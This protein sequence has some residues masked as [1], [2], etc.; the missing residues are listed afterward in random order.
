MKSRPLLILE[1]LEPRTVM[2]ADWNVVLIDSTLP[3]VQALAR[4]FAGE[5]HVMLYDGNHENA[6]QVLQRVTQAASS[7]GR[8]IGSLSILSHGT[9]GAFALGNELVSV[10]TIGRTAAAWR[11]IGRSMAPDGQIYLYGCSTAAGQVGSSLL[12]RLS[13]LTRA[14]V[15]GSTDVTGDGGDWILE[16]QSSSGFR[17]FSRVAIE[18]DVELLADF[19]GQLAW[20]GATSGTSNDA[21]HDYNNTANWSGGVID[22]SFAGVTLSGNTTLYFSASRT[23]GAGGMNLGYSG[24]FDLT[25]KSSSTTTRT[26]TLAGNLSGDLGAGNS[27]TVTLG[28]AAN[29][30]N[31]AVGA[32]R[33]LT[34]TGS[35][36]TLRLEN[37]ISGS[38]GI[39]VAGAGRVLIN[40][41]NTYSGATVIDAGATLQVG[42]GTNA[43]AQ[44]GNATSTTAASAVTVNGSLQ[45]S[46]SGSPATATYND[47][48]GIGNIVLLDSGSD[49]SLKWQ[50]DGGSFQGDAIVNA[51][52]RLQ[53]DAYGA[54]FADSS[55]ITVRSGGGLFVV[56]ANPWA[57]A[58]NLAGSGWTGD[59]FPYGALRLGPDDKTFSGTITLADDAQIF[60]T[61]AGDVFTFTGNI[62][63]GGAGHTLTVGG[64]SNTFILSGSN[65][66]GGGTIIAGTVQLGSSTALPVNGNVTLGSAARLGNLTTNASGILRL[67]GHSAE[68]GALTTDGTG[69]SNAVSNGSV[70]A[71]TLTIGG[72]D[73]TSTFSGTLSNGGS[74]ALSVAKIGSGTITLSAANAHSGTTTISGGILQL[75]NANAAQNS[76]VSIGLDNGLAFDGGIGSFAIGGLSGS[77][78]LALADTASA[79]VALSA[80]GA[81]GDTIHSGI[82]SGAGSLTKTG[83]GTLTLAGANAYAGGTTI[84][85][86]TLL[87]NNASGSA[88]GTG[89][90][91]V[92]S[93][94]T[95]GG[96]GS[97]SGAVTV[98]SGAAISPG[99]GGTSILITGNLT[100][101]S[102]ATLNATINTSTAGS[103]HDQLSIIGA[104]NLAGSTLSLSGSRTASPGEQIILISND[105]AD[106]VVGTFAGLAEGAPVTWNGAT[107][108]VS[109][110]GGSGNDVALTD[111]QFVSVSVDTTSD[112]ADGTTTSIAALLGD[113]GADGKISL[114]EAILAANNS[115]NAAGGADRI[116][117]N[118]AGAGVQTIAPASALPSITDAVVIDATSQ[119]GFGGSPII[120]I[121][122]SSAGAGINGLA[123]AVGSDGSTIR[124]LVINRFGGDGM[125]VSSNNN[126]IAGNFV[127]TDSSG[128]IDLGNSDDGIQVDGTGNLIG[129]SSAADRNV[130]SGN[131]YGI[132]LFGGSNT[133]RGNYIGVSAA[134]TADLGNAVN[135]IYTSGAG[136]TIGGAGAGEG[137]VISGNDNDGIFLGADSATIQGNFIG[138]D[139][140]GSAA[141]ANIGEGIKVEG[142]NNV[143]GGTTS[144]AGNVIANNAN[145]GI[146]LHFATAFGN[147]IQGNSIHTNG[148]LGIN[149]DITT[150]TPQPNDADDV[151]FGGPN[152]GQNYPI[153]TSA[154]FQGSDITV[155]GSLNST[156]GR[157]FRIEL[158]AG[159]AGDASGHGEGENYLGSFNITTDAGGD[160]SFSQALVA[161]VSLGAAISATATD[162]TTND[163]SEF[164]ATVS[165]TS[166]PTVTTTGSA[167]TYTEDDGAVAADGGLVITDPDSANL[168]GA[169]IQITGNYQNGQDLLSFTDTP[170]ITAT[171]DALTGTLT[172]SGSD[173]LANYQAA[174]RAVRYAN[175]SQ[176]PSTLTRS[177]SF[178]VRDETSTSPVA[179]RDITVAAV[180]DAPVITSDGGGAAASSNVAENTTAVTTV[181]ATDADGDTPTFSVTGGADAASFSINA[182]T[183]AIS[184]ISAPDYE[185]PT[186]SDVD[187]VYLV[188]VTADDGSTGT[189]SQ[190]ISVSVTNANESPTVATA[191]SATPSPVTGTTTNLSVLGGDDG[192]ESG[193]TYTWAAT[194][195][196]GGSSPAFSANGT[197]AA[198]NSTVTFDRIG[199]YTFTVTISDGSSSTTSSASVTVN[200][201]FTSV[202]VSPAAATLFPNQIQAFTATGKDQFGIA[203][204]TQPS[205]TWSLASG[206]GSIDSSSGLYTAPSSSGSATIS[207]QSGSVSGSGSVTIQPVG[208]FN[209][210]QDVGSPA[211]KGMSTFA[212][213]TYTIEGAGA[214]IWST[215]DQFQFAYLDFT[216]VGEITAR[217]TAVENTHSFAKGGVMFRDSTSANAAYA[218]VAYQPTG[219]VTFEY[220]ASNGATASFVGNAGASTPVWVR[221]VRGGADNDSFSGYYSTNGAT[222]N[223][224]G[225]QTITMGATAAV[226]LA[227]TSRDTAALNTSTFENVAVTNSTPS[228][229]TP[230]AATPSPVDGLTT[231]LSV[232]GADDGGES[233]L[234][235]TWSATTKP[236]GSNP[237]FSANVTNAAKNSTVTFDMAGDYTFEATISD[238]TSSITS[239]VTVTVNQT[240]TSITVS[241]SSVTVPTGQTQAFTATGY[242]QFGSAMSAQ[243]SMIW[244][245][246]SGVGSVDAS[247][248]YSAPGS[249]GSAVVK[250][251]SSSISGTASVNVSNTA[252]SIVTPAAAAPSPVT[253]TTTGLSVLGDDAGGEADLTYTWSVTSLPGGASAPTYSMNGT[254]SAK[255]TTATFTHAGTYVFQVAVS[256]GTDTTTDTVTVTVTQTL[257]SITV[258]PASASLN[259][260][261]TQQFTA[262]GYDQFGQE[263]AAQPAFTW[264]I[265]SG[266]GSVDAAGL[267]D[268]GASAGSAVVRAAS[269]AV[270]DDAAVTVFDAAPTIAT[271]AAASPSPAT[272]TT[273]ALGVLGAD[274]GGEANLT[275]TWSVTAKPV[276]ASDPT[277]SANGTNAAKDATATFSRA[278]DYTFEV[279]VADASGQ[280]VTSSVTV[281]VEQILSSITLSPGSASLNL[282]GAQQFSAT[283]HDQFG[284][285]MASQPS[286]T[287]SIASGVG[288][289]DSTGLYSAGASE[290]SATV[291]ATSAS[292]N[293]TASVTVTNAAPTVANPIADQNATEDVAYTFQF[294]ANVF[295]DVDG[296][297]SYTA[298]LDNGSPLPGW[299]SFDA[300]TRTFSGTPASA[301]EGTIAIRVTADDGNGGSA[302]DEFNLV[303]VQPN[304]APVAVADAYGVPE[305]GR[306][307]AGGGGAPAGVLVNDTDADGDALTAL[308]VAGPAHGRLR[309]NADGSF[310]Y[311]PDSDYHGGDSFSY[312][313]SDG[314][315]Q[316]AVVTV[317]ITVN[318]VNDAPFSN[319]P[320]ADQTLTVGESLD[321]EIAGSAFI[322]TDGD[323]LT[324]AATLG[325]GSALPAWLR[326]DAASRTFTGSSSAGDVGEVQVR[327]MVSDPSGAR[328][329]VTFVIE[330]A[331]AT[332]ALPPPSG[333]GGGGDGGGWN[334]PDNGAP[335]EIEVKPPD[336][337][338]SGRGGNGDGDVPPV[339]STS[340][341]GGAPPAPSNGGGGGNG[342]GVVPE[343]APQPDGPSASNPTAPIIYIA[344]PPVLPAQPAESAQPAPQPPQGTQPAPAPSPEAI[345]DLSIPEPVL[346]SLPHEAL[347]DATQL[348]QGLDRMHEQI[349]SDS[350]RS[351]LVAKAS[352]GLT[353]LVSAGYIIWIIRGSALFASMLSSLPLWGWLDPLPV[354]EHSASAKKRKK[355]TGVAEDRFEDDPEDDEVEKR[356]SS[357]IE[358]RPARGPERNAAGRTEEGK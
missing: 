20:I 80:G 69:A 214:D 325:D 349:S 139:A 227:V 110:Q 115:A 131:G 263:L 134:G 40:G 156:P 87:A 21:A 124:G 344:V 111:V 218:I 84:S 251:A 331:A 162:L 307:T 222:W 198:K 94:A 205:F 51:G 217:V 319:T 132:C 104:V 142:A 317:T 270:S 14:D 351:S 70:T 56:F 158:F 164:A 210:A 258:S 64:S 301:D 245:I 68:I 256:D 17:A 252:P 19:D 85:A 229:V 179:T 324:F 181:A 184:F 283:A 343:P 327:V 221:L 151:D 54:I 9:P 113:K 299:L 356:L 275:Y 201:T 332:P 348:A 120:A 271:A 100:L 288:S 190:T 143:I 62:G 71:A 15:F 197:N 121:D 338:P 148:L 81:N 101:A 141:I 6:T 260:N 244:T 204:S 117:F 321:L 140:A 261:A 30:L 23:T 41:V 328:T 8:R 336:K 231:D 202:D 340:G 235:Y 353:A 225:T 350:T 123:L 272:G 155:I 239:S 38:G 167:L 98:N 232:L 125:R 32:A 341:G 58:L 296:T 114:R 191:A 11:E 86:G 195:M 320:I 206:G 95:L 302:F 61:V 223:L 224:I 233:D 82:L 145:N 33:T 159:S 199:S 211:L 50:G 300:A 178:S 277:F 246:D 185:N 150:N 262:T 278:G 138:T 322:D 75:G 333:G 37:V 48:G 212:G 122:G 127:G 257:T 128:T 175:N 254:N 337:I 291:Q 293:G 297:L 243:P 160:A 53:F 316:S 274:D 193:L 241:P 315:A 339:P 265:A 22:D 284:V 89:N 234:T 312:R 24:N 65:T 2:S 102:S 153:L 47:F 342:T 276:G 13:K 282:N 177:V 236:A 298:T 238:G 255:N 323:V 109:Y 25:L 55:S 187:N 240:L 18:V 29:R 292:V 209:Q 176:A 34:V 330:V 129:G 90:I 303:V 311:T 266:V 295:E 60:S 170:D 106:A 313:A 286:F 136:N 83:S 182:T 304:R 97:V 108:T 347:I 253:G 59:S 165:A 72:G 107:Y 269:G 144:G 242:D 163:T 46:L 289:I 180:N 287:W 273:T 36:D 112:T 171:W 126:L 1:R 31:I 157:T 216:G 249:P 119:P 154:R 194:A 63:D 308:L 45:F 335:P 93:G 237:T 137:N 67:N 189:D 116:L 172:L 66:Y 76:V 26:L 174:L 105:G 130:L 96:T 161:S 207:A 168:A 213:G 208:I 281:T 192:G 12:S 147:A 346:P 42:D 247:G 352:A 152:N 220:R 169:T 294:A 118:I 183:G 52:A 259:L 314:S 329:S 196:P 354:L 358:T 28:D 77:G 280:T 166:A 133:V 16:A 250:A 73:A 149:I 43:T 267:Y 135:G 88:T 200:P 310:S 279:V 5:R 79:A 44:L 309:F 230:A 226:G 103:G 326:F 35:G 268:S 173:T 215:S 203:L 7:A 318:P 39:T 228:V 10:G 74:G 305:D 345:A 357:M 186:D 146:S 57:G 91:A 285:A 248:L 4:A 99:S 290:G 27:R 92:S 219:R 334:P 264:S 49:Y 3:D 188:T 78:S 306:I 355:G